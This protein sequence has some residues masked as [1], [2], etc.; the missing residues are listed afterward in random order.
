M[1]L[2][3][4]VNRDADPESV[5][6]MRRYYER[7]L[8]PA[9]KKPFL[10]D[11]QHCN[12]PLLAVHDGR[13]IL[14]LASQIASLALGFNAGA[15][16]GAAQFLETWTGNVDS[17]VMR[18]VRDSFSGLLQ[19]S[20]GWNRLHLHLCQSGAEAN[21]T[22]LG[23]CF[24]NRTNPAARRL[25]AFQGSFHGR[26]MVA[27]SATW[28]RSKREP[29]EWPGW[30]SSF[31]A[32]PEMD[33][34]DVLAPCIPTGWQAA[35]AAP[36][37]ADFPQGMRA[38]F[39]TADPLL[40]SEVEALLQ[41]RQLLASGQYYAVLVEPMQCEGGDRY[42]SARFHHG[43]LNLARAFQVPLVYDE[44]QTGFGL[45]G[46][47][48]WHRK[49]AL[50]DAQ[51]ESIS[52]D[53]VVV[54]KKA[55]V[56][57]V[58]SHR[59]CEMVEQYNPASLARGF[60]HASMMEQFREEI[61]RIEQRSRDE[62][63]TLI[64]HYG[65]HIS[66]PR[67]CG[68]CFAFDFL[69]PEMLKRFVA[70]RFRHG[71][72]YYPAGDRAA[73][74]RLNLAFRGSLLDVAWQQ[75]DAALADTCGSAANKSAV[76]VP[77]REVDS[78]LEFHQRFL[79]GKLRGLRGQT[80]AHGQAAEFLAK[81]LQR[82]QIEAEIV[83]LDQD[84]WHQY[85]QQV[86]DLQKQIYEPLRQTA[87]AKFDQ[88]IRAENSLAIALLQDSRIIAMGFAAPPVNFPAE[89]GLPDD[90][91]FLDPDTL[92]MLDLT[93]VPEYQG[94]LG[95][96]VKQALCLAAQSQ[97][98]QALQGRNRDRVARGMWAINLSLG[99]RQTRILK[100]DYVDDLPFGDCLM[101]RCEL[102]WQEEPLCLSDGVSRPLQP[103][104]LTGQFC[105]QALTSI[106]NKLT[107]S[108]FVTESYLRQLDRVFGLLPEELRHGYAASGMSECVDKIVKS[109]WLQRR[110]RQR[111][112]TI[113]NPFFGHGSFLSRALSGDPDPLFPVTRLVADERLPDRLEEVLG[114]D[115]VLAVFVEPLGCR[116]GRRLSRQQLSEISAG[117]RSRETPLVSH[118][119]ASLFYRYAPDCFLPSRLDGFRPDAG[120]LY[121][122]GQMAVCYLRE[123]WFAE[124]PLMFISTWDGDLFSLAQ[125]D[126]AL[127]VAE[128][129]DLPHLT[130]RFHDLLLTRLTE[131][132]CQEYDL[133]GGVGWFRA[134]AD[135]Q[136]SGLFRSIGADLYL[137]CPAVSAMTTF[138]ERF[139]N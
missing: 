80:A 75:L 34:D 139:R 87:I 112:V 106:P 16:F 13:Y 102:Q 78:Y 127:N 76:S 59:P 69:D 7:K 131:S 54:A 114:H 71:L 24:A 129:Q 104:D 96:L 57:A 9:E 64:D 10:I 123:R 3:Q 63:R 128:G 50:Q 130:N 33:S 40:R 115:D 60:I 28:N 86:E 118:E 68:L 135:S 14:D 32:W 74:F 29:F 30:E 108:N 52:P 85:R 17:P 82:F 12:G 6:R 2:G 84:N 97:G 101:Y 124:K 107:L 109:L 120:M 117:C 138:L 26:M 105:R 122:G 41:V 94:R 73:R 119:S 125:F 66:R 111:L 55:Q 79:A 8:I 134:P 70:H 22:A 47:F 83:F 100:D 20:L 62:L 95:R 37:G 89:R 58:L 51:G 91:Y 35:W 110:P 48:F 36:Q 61:D 4:L 77:L 21:E 31:A 103:R 56:G 121:L 5:L 18:T 98:R 39:A 42:T 43:L 137:S 72:L 133:A 27:L 65:Q 44:I 116:T 1:T 99:S 132:G 126:Q 90:P 23:M 92:Y 81:A 49:F 113:G 53:Y 88:L 93:V 136:W 25:I 19:R 38:R 15:M 46:D 11:L 45:G 67:A